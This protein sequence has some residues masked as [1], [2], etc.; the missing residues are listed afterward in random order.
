MSKR[1][2]ASI[3]PSALDAFP[4]GSIVHLDGGQRLRLDDKVDFWPVSGAWKSLV[5]EQTGHGATTMLAFLMA[6][7]Q[8]AGQFPKPAAGRTRRKVSCNHCGKPAALYTGDVVY[9]GREDLAHR[10]Y[11]V[12][13]PC[14]AWVGCH[15]RGDKTEPL[16][17][18]ADQAL[19]DARQ[20]AHAAFDPIWQRG[21]MGREE[22]YAWLAEVTGIPPTKCHIGWMDEVQCYEVIERIKARSGAWEDGALEVGEHGPSET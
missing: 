10:Y 9:P 22:A 3:E 16:G 19:R 2:N 15:D 12:C 11:W 17:L 14:K 20:A 13:W 4:K 5:S 8:I 21:E 18:L 1:S 7:R 6:Q